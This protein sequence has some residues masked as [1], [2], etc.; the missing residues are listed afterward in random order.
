MIRNQKIKGT[1]TCGHV[2]HIYIRI[3]YIYIYIYIVCDYE[4]A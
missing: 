2:D 3:I 4:I 1:F